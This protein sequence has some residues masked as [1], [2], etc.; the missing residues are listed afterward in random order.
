LKN[1]NNIIVPIIR[2][3]LA[4]EDFSLTEDEFRLIRKQYED[5][6]SKFN[7]NEKIITDKWPLNF[8]ILALYF[9]LSQKQDY[10]C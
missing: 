10:S 4:N 6:L 8:R 5:E 9:Q 7:V 3:H 1:F 2:D